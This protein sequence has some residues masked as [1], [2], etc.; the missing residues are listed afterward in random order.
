MPRKI[1]VAIIPC[2]SS[3]WAVS[4]SLLDEG[5]G[6]RI[7]KGQRRFHRQPLIGYL[8]CIQG[9]IASCAAMCNLTN[10]IWEQIGLW[11]LKPQLKDHRGLFS[12]NSI[13]GHSILLISRSRF[14]IHKNYPS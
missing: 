7:K 3:G 2:S 10:T 5:L 8:D 13:T 12:G 4:Y 14:N 11:E 6:R 9:F 1:V